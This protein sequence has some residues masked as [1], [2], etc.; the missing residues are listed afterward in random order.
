MFIL[1]LAERQSTPRRLF[2]QCEIDLSRTGFKP[3]GFIYAILS[4]E[5]RVERPPGLVYCARKADKL[6]HVLLP[7][8]I[9]CSRP[10]ELGGVGVILHAR[11]VKAA[12]DLRVDEVSEFF[13]GF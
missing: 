13:P 4:R 9:Q 8:K 3:V 6:K 1:F 10:G 7:K 2:K 12:I 11:N 5:R